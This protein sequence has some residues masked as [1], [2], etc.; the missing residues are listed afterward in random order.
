MD[1]KIFQDVKETC[2]K[3]S[4]VAFLPPELAS[5]QT[6][7]RQLTDALQGLDQALTNTIAK[8][9]EADSTRL[10]MNVKLADYIFVPISS[11]LKQQSSLTD[12]Q[13]EIICKLLLKLIDN[14]WYYPINGS[15]TLSK[16]LLSLF[17]FLVDDNKSKNG[18]L[19]VESKLSGV[20]C[21]TSLIES[22]SF[23]QLRFFQD[24]QNL[25]LLGDLIFLLLELSQT[26]NSVLLQHKSLHLLSFIYTTIL[27][28][29]EI[30]SHTLPGNI[31]KLSKLITPSSGT[32]YSVLVQLLDLISFMI[33]KVFSDQDLGVTS[34]KEEITSIEQLQKLAQAPKDQL[35][36]ELEVTVKSARQHRTTSWLNATSSQLKIALPVFL[37]MKNHQ[38]FE[39]RQSLL[40]FCIE[41]LNTCSRSLLNCSTLLIDCIS[42]L[43]NDVMLSEQ[44]S[45]WVDQNS[46]LTK[47]LD[48][49]LETK[50]AL[51]PSALSS[52]NQ[53][54][55]VA[56]VNSL[57]F[58]IDHGKNN[59]IL[60]DDLV[61][62]LHK[63]MVNYFKAEITTKRFQ[64][65]NIAVIQKIESISNELMTL[66][67][68]FSSDPAN[69]QQLFSKFYNSEVEKSLSSLLKSLGKDS[70]A[71][72]RV[73]RLLLSKD[74]DNIDRSLSL[75]IINAMSKGLDS[76]SDNVIDEFLDIEEQED[77]LDEDSLKDAIYDV[78][79]VAGEVLQE[80]NET[81]LVQSMVQSISIDSIGV[82]AS[83]LKKDFKEELID[84]LYPIVDSLASSDDQIRSHAQATATI[85]AH[86][87]Y[88]DSL[89]DLIYENS[90]YLTDSLSLKLTSDSLT[91][92]TSAVLLVLIKIGGINLVTQLTDVINT[93]FTLLDLYHGY[94][95]LS[96][97]FFVV[98]NTVIDQVYQS[99][100]S[101]YDFNKETDNV[102]NYNRPW[103]ITSISGVLDLLENKNRELVVNLEGEEIP[104]VKHPNLPFGQV[105]DSDDEDEDDEQDDEQ[106]LMKE[107]DNYQLSKLDEE[108]KKWDSQIP[109]ELYFLV[110]QFLSYGDRLIL[111]TDSIRLQSRILEI[112]VKV[113]PILSTSQMNLL[114]ILADIWPLILKLCADDD[115]R[116]VSL[117]MRVVHVVINFGGDFMAKRF[118]EFWDVLQNECKFFKFDIKGIVDSSS[119]TK[120]E[121]NVNFKIFH[122]ICDLL[123]ECIKKLRSTIPTKT[124]VDII[125]VTISLFP[126][127]QSYDF[128]S[129]VAWMV[130][131]EKL[132]DF[133]IPLPSPV[134]LESGLFEFYNY[135]N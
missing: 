37:K 26:Q 85:I 130:K 57:K 59:R 88:D 16:Q 14:C 76:T 87:C 71:F 30:L 90:D 129:D 61:S 64:N 11:I 29:G 103:G 75:W 54:K 124:V 24:P 10:V 119:L 4:Q 38:K 62:N 134:E 132:A 110:Q 105:P 68:N 25:P 108:K 42:F 115:I 12:I 41:I 49:K 98:F 47:I 93:M 82:S 50:I 101:Q 131:F 94:D 39:V 120:F 3:L 2:I 21:L 13:T 5:S 92:R 72:I 63:S 36:N 60:V 81:G 48:L 109:S 117:L 34:P 121:G 40:K 1:R 58:F 46:D 128:Y 31:S 80:S 133:D 8:H 19:S 104:L 70:T 74:E 69:D 22:L 89:Y 125:K 135:N 28:D 73:T 95:T 65:K 126:D 51:L 122:S 107:I 56:D 91:P 66:D 27:N 52:S 100:L 127:T 18:T 32:H 78:L 83:I 17:I 123:I 113:F 33:S 79:A 96:E 84:Y 106:A 20:N 114:P 67:R 102:Q 77:E 35:K 53:D 97:G 111:S 55:I 43:N 45:N 118:G 6:S 7:S 23:Q 15:L 112:F 44:I 99:Y 116:I 86:E 9:L